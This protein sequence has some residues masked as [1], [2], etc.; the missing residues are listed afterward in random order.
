MHR[1]ATRESEILAQAPPEILLQELRRR[2]VTP[3]SV[4]SSIVRTVKAN[5]A[6]VSAAL[7]KREQ[8]G[9]ESGRSQDDLA[10]HE[11]APHRWLVLSIA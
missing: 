2:H 4:G 9:S 5:E 7:R 3:L 10:S 11:G 8:A 1:P 6:E